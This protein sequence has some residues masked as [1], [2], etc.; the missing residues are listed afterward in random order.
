MQAERENKYHGNNGNTSFLLG[1]QNSRFDEILHK[2]FVGEPRPLHN[3]DGLM[4]RKRTIDAPILS[5]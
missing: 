4:L 2:F 1:I 5:L 3:R